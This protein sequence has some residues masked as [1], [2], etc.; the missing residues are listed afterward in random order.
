MS[1]L[2]IFINSIE[3]DIVYDSLNVTKENNLFSKDFRLQ[4]NSYPFLIVENENARKAFGSS[5]I[6]SLLKKNKFTAT[7]FFD[8]DEFEGEIK[9]LSIQKNF[10]K[11]DL[12]F[13]VKFN[14]LLN[15]K[16][17]E[18]MPVVNVL[19]TTLGTTNWNDYPVYFKICR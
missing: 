16:I 2:R 5:D 18:F 13:G 8:N 10:R 17:A 14:S 9:V 4:S 3:L 12:N 19:N 6:T 11:C 7:V 1:D 15:K